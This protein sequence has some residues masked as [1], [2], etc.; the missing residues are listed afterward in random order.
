MVIVAG[1]ELWQW[2]KQA[3]QE[4]LASGIAPKEVDWLLQEI[5][6]LDS[7][8]LRL[9]LFKDFEHIELPFPLLQL[10]QLW[11]RR[12]QE[13]VPLQYLAG[14]T[15]WRQ[16]SLQVAPGVLIPRPETEQIIDL[17]LAATEAGKCEGKLKSGVWVDLG[18][19][20]G[21]IAVGLADVFPQATIHAVDISPTALTIAQNNAQNLGFAN[22][23]KF[24]QGSWWQP[25]AALK[26]KVSGMVANPPYIPATQV[27]QL[28]PE[29]AKHEPH[30]ALNGGD[31]GLDCIRHLISTSATYLCPGGIWLIE[32][33][34]GQAEVVKQLLYQDGSYSQIQIYRD[35]AG[36][37]RFALAYR[38]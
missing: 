32:M 25:L 20:S 7:L 34:A 31:D 18:T 30:L 11:Q 14:S 3:K 4:A 16:F 37:E 19:G 38:N 28:Q 9:E 36:I 17:A 12:V 6:N 1:T 35:L 8:T 15:G 24:H 23:I 2:R 26:G 27:P 22:R 29:V 5:T 33:M 21:A 10:E 13:S